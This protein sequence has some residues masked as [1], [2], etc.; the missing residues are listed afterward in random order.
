MKKIYY[1]ANAR[2][3]TERAH[4]IQL[5]KMCEAFLEEGVDLELIAPKRK[6]T[7][8]SIKKFYGL[9]RD[10]PIK[11]IPVVDLY[12]WGRL[13]LLISSFSF[14]IISFIYLFLKRILGERDAVIYTVDLDQFSFFLIPF[15]GVPYFVEIHEERKNKLLNYFFLKRASGIIT[16]NQLI[17][18]RLIKKF[19]LSPSKI[20]VHPN[21]IDLQSF[22]ANTSKEEVR[23]KLNLPSDKKLIVY[24]GKFHKWKGLEIFPPLAR[25]LDNV[26]IYLVGGSADELEKFID[27]EIAPDNLVCMGHEDYKKIPLWLAAAD[28]LV[29]LGTRRD[30]YSYYYTS[31]MKI[32]EYM[33][34]GRPIVASNTP[35]IRQ[36][37]S[38]N[39]VSFYEPDNTLNLAETITRVLENQRETN[40]KIEKAHQNVK[41]FSW[42]KRTKSILQFIDISV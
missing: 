10:I 20:I 2:M 37:V 38:E 7:A 1:I 25:K 22:S 5:I 17:K 40:A 12:C 19:N 35:A 26:L 9:K 6:T 23:K 18:D 14:I 29:V 11:K 8:E 3:P 28:V 36:I 33:A 31:P 41:N 42:E 34:A 21:G 27:N 16:I 30:E 4:G 13:G 32:F 15:T 24:T 39:E